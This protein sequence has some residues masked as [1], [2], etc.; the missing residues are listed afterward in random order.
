MKGMLEVDGDAKWLSNFKL[1]DGSVNG[2]KILE[3]RSQVVRF[4]NDCAVQALD[5]VFAYEETFKHAEEG[6]L[7]LKMD[8]AKLV[9]NENSLNLLMAQLEHPTPDKRREAFRYLSEILSV[10]EE[11][12]DFETIGELKT[13]LSSFAA[14]RGHFL[15]FEIKI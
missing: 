7:K 13:R 12:G 9:K 6:G 14:A 15:S 8:L 2:V 1:D 11:H 4:A 5:E 3:C 10:C